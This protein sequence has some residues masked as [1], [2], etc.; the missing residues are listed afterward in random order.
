MVGGELALY[1][2]SMESHV[3]LKH[4]SHFNLR[5]CR[6]SS[7]VESVVPTATVP[8]LSFDTVIFFPK[9]LL[10]FYLFCALFFR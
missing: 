9:I 1:T 2:P 4:G 8:V 10:G 7:A 5:L 3:H 6:G